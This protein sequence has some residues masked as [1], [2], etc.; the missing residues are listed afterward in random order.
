MSTINLSLAQQL[1]K[2]NGHF[3]DDPQVVKIVRYD[4]AFGDV[5][6]AAIYIHQEYNLYEESPACHNVKVLWELKKGGPK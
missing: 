1:I 4:N 6:Y 2:S 3:K 5:S